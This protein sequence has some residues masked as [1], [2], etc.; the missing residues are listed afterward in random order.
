[1]SRPFLPPE[2][3][4]SQS[5]GLKLTSAEWES[6]R[7][8]AFRRKMPPGRLAREFVV[9]ALDASNKQPLQP[10]GKENPA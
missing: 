10:E 9:A 6:L 7:V 8:E 3:R 5:V 4:A 2:V 1:M